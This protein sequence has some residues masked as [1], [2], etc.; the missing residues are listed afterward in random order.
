MP[1]QPEKNPEGFFFFFH[2]GTTV[3]KLG[4]SAMVLLPFSLKPYAQEIVTALFVFLF[5]PLPLV[6]I[7]KNLLG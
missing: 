5:F 1:I 2:T 6:L 7:T 3:L 4:R